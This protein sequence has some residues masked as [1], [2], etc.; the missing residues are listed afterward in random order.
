MPPAHGD[1]LDTD[2]GLRFLSPG[3]RRGTFGGLNRQ[4]TSIARAHLD[5]LVRRGEA[6]PLYT[7]KD[8]R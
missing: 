8:S 6:A 5:D 4:T 1:P 2:P 3:T 7:R